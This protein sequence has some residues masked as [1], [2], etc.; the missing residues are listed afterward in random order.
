[1]RVSASAISVGPPAPDA[2]LALAMALLLQG[3][4]KHRGHGLVN[5]SAR[6]A[7]CAGLPGCY[8]DSRT[9][10]GGC[11]EAGHP[12]SLTGRDC[13]MTDRQH[14]VVAHA[15]R[16]MAEGK[17]DRRDFLRIATLLGVSATA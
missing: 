16:E 7:A 4:G 6:R 3:D 11:R 15:G 1:M 13:G 8:P 17:L 14:P 9:R 2:V 10:A 5:S 12:R